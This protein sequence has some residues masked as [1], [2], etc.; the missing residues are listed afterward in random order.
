[1]DFPFELIDAVLHV[2]VWFGSLINSDKYQT[3]SFIS[4]VISQVSNH[5][6]VIFAYVLSWILDNIVFHYPW[7]LKYKQYKIAL[8]ATRALM[9]CDHVSRVL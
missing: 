8:V 4:K 2:I 3:S 7:Y 5:C 9:R 1:M 6:K